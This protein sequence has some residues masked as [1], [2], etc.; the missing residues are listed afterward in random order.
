MWVNTCKSNTYVKVLYVSSVVH[1]YVQTKVHKCTHVH[2]VGTCIQLCIVFGGFE[3]QAGWTI[4]NILY[5]RMYKSTAKVTSV[6]VRTVV[7]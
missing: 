5:I 1:M 6:Y 7:D 2:T 3:Y 4:W